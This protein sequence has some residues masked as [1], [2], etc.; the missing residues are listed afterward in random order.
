MENPKDG[1]A[2]WFVIKHTKD[3]ALSLDLFSKYGFV[4]VDATQVGIS[5]LTLKSSGTGRG[6]NEN[7]ERKTRFLCTCSL[8]VELHKARPLVISRGA[9]IAFSDPYHHLN[10]RGTS[11]RVTSVL[12]DQSKM[13]WGNNETT[14]ASLVNILSPKSATNPKFNKLKTETWDVIT[15]KAVT[16]C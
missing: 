12:K 16:F 1:L 2:D 13:K 10:S 4:A 11:V 14:A 8:R 3:Q 7:G 6:L 15:K 5:R 9:S